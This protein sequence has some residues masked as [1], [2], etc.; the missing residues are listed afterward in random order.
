MRC[1][2]PTMPIARS[3]MRSKKDTRPFLSLPTR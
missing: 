2:L 3:K 1:A